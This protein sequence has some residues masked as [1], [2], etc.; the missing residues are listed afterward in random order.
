METAESGVE[1]RAKRNAYR[2]FLVRCR[3]EEGAG[4]EGEPAW[5]FTVEQAG[6][7]APRR[8]FACLSDVA[9]HLQAELAT[10]EVTLKPTAPRRGKRR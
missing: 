5:R 4:P 6:G 7:N 3:L 10:C 2:C 8:C 9:S 1:L